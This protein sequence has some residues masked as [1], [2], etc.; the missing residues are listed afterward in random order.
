MLT[1][2]D[3]IQPVLIPVMSCHWLSPSTVNM[4]TLHSAVR[5]KHCRAGQN[6]SRGRGY[7]FPSG[8]CPLEGSSLPE[9]KGCC[10]LGV[11]QHQ[12]PCCYSPSSLPKASILCLSSGISSPLFSHLCWSPGNMV[13]NANFCVVPLNGFSVSN[14]LSLAENNNA[15]FLPWLLSMYFLGSG[16]LGWES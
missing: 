11:T 2:T 10:H 16:V 3:L 6:P 14:H 7:C 1:P 15:T 5:F 13:P 4:V 8:Y 9:H 12:D